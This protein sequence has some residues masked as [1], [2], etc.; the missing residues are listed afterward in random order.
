MTEKRVGRYFSIA[1][2]Y[3]MIFFKNRMADLG[4][5]QSHHGVLITL[6]KKQGISQ[7]ALRQKL[8]IDKANV[9]RSVKKLIQDGFV[10]RRHDPNDKRSYLLYVSEKGERIRPE[11]ESMFREWN[12]IL[13][14]GFTQ[15]ETDQLIGY[16]TRISDNVLKHHGAGDLRRCCQKVEE[17]KDE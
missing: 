3:A 9:T 8:N 11:I 1:Y 14:E 12:D 4:L 2:R 10:E 13:L 16:M 17:D 6:Y 7:E 15:E 5:G